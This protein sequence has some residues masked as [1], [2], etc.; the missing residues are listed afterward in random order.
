M[1]SAP[2]DRVKARV[3]QRI[4]EE[5]ECWISTYS[6]Q[7]AGYAQVGWREDGRTGIWLAHRVAWVATHGPIPEGMT[8]DHLCK[9]R[10]CVN[11]GH[12]RLLSN[13]ENA[14]RTAGRDW[15]TGECINGHPNANLVR[16][17]SGRIACRICRADSQRRYAARKRLAS[18]T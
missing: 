7:S 3:L 9:R 6:V 8:V 16:L 11:P 14:R 13:F 4:I 5:G 17:T 12:L 2:P 18:R 10:T 1:E 15:P